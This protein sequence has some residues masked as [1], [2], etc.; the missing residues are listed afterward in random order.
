MA[1]AGWTLDE[2]KAWLH[3]RGEADTVHRPSGLLAT[4]LAGAEQILDTPAKRAAAVA[5]WRDS[6]AAARRRHGQSTAVGCGPRSPAVRRMVV[7]A[8]TR[9]PLPPQPASA[10]RPT[11]LTALSDADRQ[12][13]RETARGEFLRGETTLI[14]STIAVWGRS[15]AE[16]LYGA[17]LV[18]LRE[19]SWRGVQASWRGLA[20]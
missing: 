3:L 10:S 17:P 2:V 9:R 6:R 11:S 5:D 12:T 14:D 4:L 18:L 15:V 19:S 13:L 16:E 20:A 1:D 7:D 8:L